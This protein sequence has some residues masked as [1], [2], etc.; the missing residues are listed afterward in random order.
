MASAGTRITWMTLALALHKAA[1]NGRCSQLE[2]S[3]NMGCLEC[4]GDFLFSYSSVRYV[5]VHAKCPGV[6]FRVLQAMVL[7]YIALSVVFQ[8]T[9]QGYDQVLAVP[10]I[11][12]KGV[13]HVNGTE[14]V[15]FTDLVV[16]PQL[17][18]ARFVT[19]SYEVTSGGR[20]M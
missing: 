4:I 18:S 10:F 7:L 15:D 2:G 17:Q 14:V 9:Y 5:N 8:K 19:T 20:Y 6:V 3:S 13:A 1:A 11:K 12:F 16:P